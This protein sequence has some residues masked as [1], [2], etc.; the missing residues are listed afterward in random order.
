MGIE[1]EFGN[2]KYTTTVAGDY[3]V[4]LETSA[5]DPVDTVGYTQRAAEDEEEDGMPMDQV[6]DE[7]VF[8]DPEAWDELAQAGEV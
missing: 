7:L 8:T 3:D 1:L 6:K 4:P 5:I 2:P